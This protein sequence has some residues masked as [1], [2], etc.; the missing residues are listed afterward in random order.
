MFTTSVTC[1]SLTGVTKPDTGRVA[2]A[3]ALLTGA[4]QAAGGDSGATWEAAGIPH[5]IDVYIDTRGS[6]EGATC[7]S[8]SCREE[9]SR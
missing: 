8:A 3:G 2:T 9:N 1:F 6:P 4:S 7:S 5:V